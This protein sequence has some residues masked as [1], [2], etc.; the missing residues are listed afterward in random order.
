MEIT[1]IVTSWALGLAAALSLFIAAGILISWRNKRDPELVLG[2]VGSVFAATVLGYWAYLAHP[3]FDEGEKTEIEEG[4]PPVE[5]RS[6]SPLD[7]LKIQYGECQLVLTDTVP[8]VRSE[9]EEAI[10][11][12]QNDLL[13]AESSRAKAPLNEDIREFA[14][15]LVLINKLEDQYQERALTL[16]RLE[17]KM[18][19]QNAVDSISLEGMAD[20]QSEFN[21]LIAKNVDLELDLKALETSQVITEAEVQAVL[22]KLSAKSND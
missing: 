2:A 17:R 3:A 16:K 10:V 8:K 18:R 6:L 1:L 13:L 21:T 20:L 7:Q 5:L 9:A 12:S 4:P 11:A 15:Y 14:R 22:S 19:V